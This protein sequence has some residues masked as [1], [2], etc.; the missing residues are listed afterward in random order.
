MT[1]PIFR[2]S[3]TATVN[4]TQLKITAGDVSL[5]L[6][7]ATY[8]RASLTVANVSPEDA[9]TI[10]PRLGVRCLIDARNTLTAGG[11]FPSETLFPSDLLVPDGDV[12]VNRV[13]DLAIR[14]REVD[15]ASRTIRLELASDEALL[16]D[17][18]PL[19]A[20]I[21]ARVHEGSLRAVCNYV[22]GKIGAALE[23]GDTDADVTAYWTLTNLF[24]DPSGANAVP[25]WTPGTGTPNITRQSTPTPFSGANLVR[26]QAADTGT[27]TIQQTDRVVARPGVPYTYSCYLSSDVTSLKSAYLVIRWHDAAGSKIRD[28]S[29]SPLMTTTSWVRRSVTAVAPPNAAAMSVHI[30][31]I[32]PH[33]IGN[34]HYLDS[35]SLT[36]GR[37]LVDVF[38]GNTPPDDHYTYEWEGDALASSSTRHPNI[39]RLP[40]LYDWPPGVSAWDFLQPIA[41]S[42]GLALFCDEH[43]V[44][45]LYN[46]NDYTAP[47]LLS[48]AGWNTTQGTD[49]ISLDDDRYCT[50]VVVVYKWRDA[51]DIE[52]EQYDSAGSAF[53]PDG[54]TPGKVLTFTLERPFPGLGMAAAILTRRGNQGREQDITALVNWDA[55]PAMDCTITLPATVEQRGRITSVQWTLGDIV[56][57]VGTQGLADVIP[58][59]IDSLPGTIDS[60]VGTIDSL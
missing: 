23:A 24:P 29:S 54:V 14:T 27:A 30:V 49:R 45:R 4:G 38:G 58:G 32:G 42:A 34:L 36:E 12:Y 53:K 19:V 2:P 33:V 13:F 40:A 8:A 47:G 37:D 15:H 22:L 43:R 6:R 5:E 21:G 20:D 59:S 31:W 52:R 57:R 17:Y 35:I 39:E 51:D 56:M 16:M 25:A 28:D 60:L 10:D 41:E 46:P 26:V 9:E 50:G 18:A 44:W 7:S 1:T 48:L 55:S 11:L 3:A